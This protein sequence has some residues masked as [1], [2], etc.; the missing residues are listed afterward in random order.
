M[1]NKGVWP[2]LKKFL[3]RYL[4]NARVFNLVRHILGGGQVEYVAG[5]LSKVP[6]QRVVDLAC[7]TGD[8][9]RAVT[10]E[11]VGVDLCVPFIAYAQRKYGGEHKTFLVMDVT[12]LAIPRKSFDVALIV[13]AI[14]HFSDEQVL[15]ILA[16]AAELSTGHVLLID[17]VPKRNVISR[18]CYALDRGDYLR[19]MEDQRALIEKT[20]TLALIEE[21]TFESTSRIYRHSVFLCKITD[22]DNTRM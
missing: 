17:M 8:I 14:H 13:N 1:K 22:A 9:S 19:S 2:A 16:Q 15:R 21:G 3:D 4:D 20:G 18:I 6:H 7:G 10:K 11:Y 12:A 5:I